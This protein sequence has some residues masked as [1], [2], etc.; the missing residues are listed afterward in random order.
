MAAG[1][2]LLRDIAECPCDGCSIWFRA[3]APSSGIS[4][5][6]AAGRYCGE[7][8]PCTLVFP[9]EISRSNPSVPPR[10]VRPGLEPFPGSARQ[11][12][13]ELGQDRR[14]LHRAGGDR[15]PART[16]WTRRVAGGRTLG[17]AALT[18]ASSTARL[19]VPESASRPDRC[20]AGGVHGLSHVRPASARLAGASLQCRLERT[21]PAPHIAG[22]QKGR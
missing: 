10:G 17:E 2:S 19:I 20:I 22:E 5:S 15:R 14:Q 16:T 18:S 3:S 12:V 7:L 11:V 6:P 9:P 8:R 4:G 1:R 13:A 21:F